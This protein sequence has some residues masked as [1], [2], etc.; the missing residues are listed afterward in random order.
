MLVKRSF[1]FF[2]LLLLIRFHNSICV[3]VV[4][5][6]GV[7]LGINGICLQVSLLGIETM[8]YF[9]IS[10]S[11]LLKRIRNLVVIFNCYIATV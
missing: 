2:K 10:F 1:F 6:G 9:F 11:K 4:V 7:G 3:V 5:G 8:N